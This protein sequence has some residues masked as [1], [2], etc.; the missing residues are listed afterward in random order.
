VTLNSGHKLQSFCVN[1]SS[2]IN[3]FEMLFGSV[4]HVCYPQSGGRTVYQFSSQSLLF[5]LI[6]GLCALISEMNLEFSTTF[7]NRFT[8]LSKIFFQFAEVP[9]LVL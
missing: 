9:Y 8:K 3:A 1:V 6:S 7:M 4:F 2:V 5:W